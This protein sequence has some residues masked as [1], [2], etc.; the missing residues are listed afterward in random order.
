MPAAMLAYK[1]IYLNKIPPVYS[2]S[3]GQL[4]KSYNRENNNLLLYLEPLQITHT[5]V[6][7]LL[8]YH[9]YP[10]HGINKNLLMPRVFVVVS[11]DFCCFKLALLSL[12]WITVIVKQA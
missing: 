9:C 11:G 10:C 12:L 1:V 4:S 5:A 6:L 8:Y 3:P 7:S 2:T